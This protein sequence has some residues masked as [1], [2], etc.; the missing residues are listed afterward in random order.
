MTQIPHPVTGWVDANNPHH[1]VTRY[2]KSQ[3]LGSFGAVNKT[4]NYQSK[5]I[6]GNSFSIT[7]GA[8]INLVQAF[9]GEVSQAVPMV[10]GPNVNINTTGKSIS[11]P[12]MTKSKSHFEPVDS[13]QAVMYETEGC[14]ASDSL[15]LEMNNRYCTFVTCYDG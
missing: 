15:I 9:I 7:R 13:H 10:T 6:E 5:K 14:N 12:G 4:I 3:S 2:T 8:F 11:E 1:C